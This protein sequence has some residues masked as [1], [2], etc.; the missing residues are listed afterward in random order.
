MK[1]S[2]PANRGGAEKN[3]TLAL[4]VESHSGDGQGI[5]HL[6]DGRVVFVRGALPGERVEAQLLKVGKTAAWARVLRVTEPSPARIPSD[7]PHYPRCGG[8]RY[9]HMTYEEECAAKLGKVNDALRRIGG[10][11]VAASVILG[12]KNTLRY[13]NKV[14]FPVGSGPSIGFYR[15][16][17]HDVVDVEDCLLQPEGAAAIRRAVKEYM[18]SNGV[19]PYDETGGTGLLRHLY[20]RFNRAGECLC[21]LVVNGDRLPGEG[22]LVDALRAAEPKIVGILLNENTA[23]TN[24]VL[25]ERYRTLWGENTLQE[26]L[27]GFS[28]RLSPQS[29][30][31]VNRAQTER[32]YGKALEFA[33]LTGRETVLDLYCGIGTISL[34]LAREA[35][36]V[37][38]A[39][40]VPE[41][42]A[43]AEENARRSGVKNV[44]FLCGD[45]GQ[46][47]RRLAEE[48]VRPQ[49]ICVDPPRKGLQEEV[50]ALLAGMAPERIVYVS[51]DPATLARD[52]KRFAG[53]G[54]RLARAEAVDLF[55]RTEHVETVALL[56]RGR[57]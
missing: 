12:A 36:Q 4:T 51:C 14:Q 22:V 44:R 15:A 17:S 43:D 37:I 26:T 40:V 8:C 42:I 49:V 48:G 52:V 57:T 35:G 56:R 50:P 23:D 5:A 13:R 20:L 3:Q 25:G 7:C 47:A 46:T 29:F 18:R 45:A 16:R 32:L 33:A 38:G 39:E 27:C 41:A 2:R 1:G 28:F 54:Y 34:C 31:Q 9:R 19:A 11:E 24:V 30:F 53:L 21:C 55:P 10:A 6:P